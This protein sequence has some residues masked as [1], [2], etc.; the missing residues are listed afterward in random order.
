MKAADIR[1]IVKR[2]ETTHSL[3]EEEA[4]GLL[5]PLGSN[6]VPYLREA[7]PRFRKWQ[8]RVSLVFHSIRFARSNEDAF[9]LGLS[10]TKDKATL[11]RYRACGLL[12]YSLRTDALPALEALLSHSDSKTVEDAA[13]AIDAI[14]HQNHHYF[15]DRTHSG[16][17]TWVVNDEDRDA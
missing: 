17:T 5:R 7:Y 4:W 13:A 8:G 10:A 12:A 6:A 11:V 1:I 15:V 16:R 2:L 9:Q 3:E 14:R